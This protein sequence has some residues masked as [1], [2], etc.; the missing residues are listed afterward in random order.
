L[1]QLA[2]FFFED[3]ASYVAF[4]MKGMRG[5]VVI[6]TFLITTTIDDTGY[7]APT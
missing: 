2:A 1:H 5:I 6:A 4:G 7:L 3:A